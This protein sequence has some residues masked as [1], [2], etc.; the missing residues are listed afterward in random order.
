MQLQNSETKP[1][2]IEQEFFRLLENISQKINFDL[3][4]ENEK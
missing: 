3:E 2:E 1:Q 4:Q